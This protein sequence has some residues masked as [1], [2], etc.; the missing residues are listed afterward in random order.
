MK[1]LIPVLVLAGILFFPAVGFGQTLLESC[2][3]THDLSDFNG[4]RGLPCPDARAGGVTS[5][6]AVCCV[7]NLIKTVGDWIFAG[8]LVLASIFFILGAFQ[9]VT[10]G[11]SPEAVSSARNKIIY[12][13]IGV[14]L[15]FLAQ[16]LVNV[17]GG[18]VSK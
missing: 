13:V 1:K 5:E 11:G 7:L 17:I 3:V 9:F 12:A 8:V 2:T 6:D 16:G 14:A 4:S 18:I 10:A 15:A